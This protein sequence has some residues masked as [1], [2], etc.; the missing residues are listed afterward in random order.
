MSL[1]N[2]LDH[3]KNVLETYGGESLAGILSHY[4]N[5]ISQRL[6]RQ[7]KWAGDLEYLTYVKVTDDHAALT[8]KQA[9][10]SQ[11]LSDNLQSIE[12]QGAGQWPR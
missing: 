7:Y 3:L 11:I 4:D 2:D 6:A 1:N 5:A 10:E 8:R 12:Q 9:L